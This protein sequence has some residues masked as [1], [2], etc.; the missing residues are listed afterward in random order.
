M[1]NLALLIKHL[2]KNSYEKNS[3]VMYCILANFTY[4]AIKQ[5]H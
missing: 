5:E 1:L 4:G 3:F 2:N